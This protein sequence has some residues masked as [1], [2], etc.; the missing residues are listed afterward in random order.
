MIQEFV[1]VLSR[2][3]CEIENMATIMNHPILS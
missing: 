1:I 3:I 2:D